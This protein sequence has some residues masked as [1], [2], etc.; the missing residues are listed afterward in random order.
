MDHY[1]G[2]ELAKGAANFVALT[3]C[4]FL[5]RSG[6]VH[7]ERIAIVHGPRRITYADFYRRSKLLASAL[8]R[9][10]V[11]RGDPISVML[12][13]TP[14]Y[15]E[16]LMGIPMSGAV[17][18]C[19][20][21][22]LDA[23]NVAFC[24]KHSGARMLITDTEFSSTVKAA[25]DTI[26]PAERPF[27]IDV[28]DIQCATRG[29]ALGAMSYEDLVASG[30]PSYQYTEIT[31]EWDA[32]SLCYTSGT[33]ADPK[34]VVLHHRGT[35]L[36]AMNNAVTW[37]MD[38]HA[39]YLWTLPMFHCTGWCFPWTVTMLAGTHVCLRKVE[40]ALIY[41]LIAEERVTHF[42]GAPVIMSTMVGHTGPRTWKHDLKMMVAASAPPAPVLA[43]MQKLG[44]DCTHV[45]GLTEVFGP[46]VVCEWKNEWNSLPLDQQAQLKAR[47]G[48]RYL[49]LEDLMV[50]DA[51]T[52]V[53]VPRDGKTMGEVFMRGNIVM[54]GYL[55]N[56]SATEKSLK[57]GWFHT[58]D[59]AVWGEDGYISLRDRS[60]DVIISG[61]ENISTLEVEAIMYEHPKV[62]EVAVVA[63]PCERWGETPCAF[64][65]LKPDSTATDDEVFQWCREKMPKYMVPRT[66]V[67][68]PLAKTV[69]GKV[70]KHVLRSQAKE[71][72]KPAFENS[73]R[74]GAAPQARL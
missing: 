61:G 27:I 56:P 69:T 24:I 9:R 43:A 25:L 36:N 28:D 34:G 23:K 42:C 35:Y 68:G 52:M 7:P 40:A 10:G 64:V 48:V 29:P 54:K 74:V 55:K 20:N 57:G 53:P 32:L 26:P 72:Q 50:A 13:N 22:R 59:L 5:Q 63:R 39:V 1:N 18:N 14:E 12:A 38:R 41:K 37:G 4:Q 2:P 51:E 21:T 31:D 33:T 58:G 71:L 73:S 45:Y 67:F 6:T 47:Q 60:K 44:I 16:C 70:Q 15:L 17:I 66:Y 19:L 46:D 3:P 8:L 30:D 65:T 11:K 49:A 62:M